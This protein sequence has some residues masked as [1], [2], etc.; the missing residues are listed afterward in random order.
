M[1]EV[2]GIFMLLAAM[3]VL[4]LNPNMLNGLI[5][6][7][8]KPVEAWIADPD[9]AADKYKPWMV[10]PNKI[11]RGDNKTG[12]KVLDGPDPGENQKISDPGN[13]QSANDPGNKESAKDP[14]EASGLVSTNYKGNNDPGAK[15]KVGPD[16]GRAYAVVEEKKQDRHSKPSKKD[17][18][19]D[20]SSYTKFEFNAYAVAVQKAK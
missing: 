12:D 15:W 8:K 3:I 13:K 20:N 6:T 5:N 4:W 7:V 17:S 10:D 9:N 16:P 19:K 11:K 2:I 14:G 1:K 18:S